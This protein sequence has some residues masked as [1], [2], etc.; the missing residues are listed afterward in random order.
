M[1]KFPRIWKVIPEEFQ[2]G[3][4]EGERASMRMALL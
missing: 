3:M 2:R 1:L 4:E